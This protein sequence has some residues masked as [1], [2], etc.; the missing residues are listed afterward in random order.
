[1][2]I[3]LFKY[4]GT[5]QAIHTDSIKVTSIC[6]RSYSGI[7]LLFHHRAQYEIGFSAEVGNEHR[8]VEL[9]VVYVDGYEYVFTSSFVQNENEMK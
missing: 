2:W 6:D 5:A 9:I 3:N 4:E 1:M 8:L 7:F